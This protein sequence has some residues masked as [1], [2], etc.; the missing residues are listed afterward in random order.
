VVWFRL[1]AFVWMMGLVTATFV[2]DPGASKIWVGAATVIAC[3]GTAS[4]VVLARLDRLDTWW[5]VVID[6]AGAIFILTA[7]GLAGSADLFYGGYGL[8]WLILVVWAFP[9][10]LP[11]AVAICLVI[12][13]QL[14]GNEIGIRATTL[15]DTVGDVAVW[16][17]SGIVY[18]WALWAI[19]STEMQRN[20]AEEALAR[21]R[22]ERSLVEARAVI[23]ADIHD[24]VL[25][26]LAHIRTH[27]VDQ[28]AVRVAADQD[29]E[30]RRYLD[31]LSAAHPDGLEVLLRSAAWDVEDRH[32]VEIEVVSVRDCPSS[33]AVDAL[34][35]AAKE[36]MTNAARHSEASRV[37]VFSEV[38]SEMIRVYVRDTG[39]GFEVGERPSG[40][41]I[42]HSM[43][44]RVERVGGTVE[45]SSAPGRGTEIALSVPRSAS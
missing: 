23:A 31:R 20:R 21:E 37:S 30:L 8:S 14:L 28:E 12:A 44:G 41:G 6:G 1:L 29:R 13:A 27:S 34:V 42:R 16:L 7:P 24:S 10:V 4:T 43:M 38:G 32:G 19:R 15:T 26:T 17:V 3:A 18:G 5:W 36:A 25:Q 39:V 22:V 40:R 35:G 33:P 45:V 11:V 9:A 2:D